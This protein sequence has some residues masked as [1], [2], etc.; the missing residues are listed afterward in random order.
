MEPF[1]QLPRKFSFNWCYFSHYSL[2]LK[3]MQ[4]SKTRRNTHLDM[5]LH[6]EQDFVLSLCVNDKPLVVAPSCAGL[7]GLS[8]PHS[9]DVYCQSQERALSSVESTNSR[10]SLLLSVIG[11]IF[12]W[13]EDTTRAILGDAFPINHLQDFGAV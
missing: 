9:W 7:L 12:G 13:P 3:L 6:S 8:S 10:E 4:T 11:C 5:L 2:E 1:E